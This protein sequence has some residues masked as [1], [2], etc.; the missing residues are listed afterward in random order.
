M[1]GEPDT[2]SARWL[3]DSFDAVD[4]AL[5]EQLQVD[6]RASF[7]QLAH[8]VGVPEATVRRRVKRL[9]DDEVISVVGVLNTLAAE[10]AVL[11]L[12]EV[13]ADRDPEE[14]AADLAEWPE[15]TWVA[16]TLGATSVVAEVIC[17]GRQGLLA[18]VRRTH[19]LAGV[20]DVRG[21]LYLKVVKTTYAGPPPT[22]LLP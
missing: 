21:H 1:T 10:R 18:V 14:V 19:R 6:G 11:G 2:W 3:E 4:R 20:R 15:V 7:K 5:I 8:S 22:S 17:D 9:L 12:L 16:V 13:V